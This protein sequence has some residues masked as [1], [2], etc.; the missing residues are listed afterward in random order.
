MPPRY[1][2][3]SW[4]RRLIGDLM[5]FARKVPSIPVERTMNLTALARA[6]AAASP[7]PGWTAL[8]VK[9]F[10]LVTREFADLRTS[11]I[12]NPWDHLVL[13]ERSVASVAIAKTLPS[14]E[15]AV[16]FTKVRDPEGMPLGQV[17]NHLRKSRSRPVEDSGGFRLIRRISMLPR[18]LR[19]LV[20]W[21]TLDWSGRLR[22][23]YFG[24][25]G[26]SSYGMQGAESLHPLSPLASTL[27]AGTA[28]TA[29][30]LSGTNI[31]PFPTR[32]SLRTPSARPHPRRASTGSIWDAAAGNWRRVCFAPPAAKLAP[33]WR[34]I[35]PRPIVKPSPSG[36]QGWV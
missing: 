5:H 30:A 17:D 8:F 31:R 14:G 7:A 32:N 15:Q 29:P 4:P 9:A 24:T 1:I 3:L 36:D 25:F 34:R 10:G 35:A 16:L 6:R 11:F 20:W 28:T 2:P 26:V 22:E 21:V 19:R 13:H 23:K 33:W 12:A 18:F 27:T